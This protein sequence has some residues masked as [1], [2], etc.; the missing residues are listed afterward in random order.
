MFLAENINLNGVFLD[1]QTQNTDTYFAA[2]ALSAGYAMFDNKIGDK[3]RVVWGAR[4]E[5]FQ[6]F[7]NATDLAL[8]D[9]IV[10]TEKVDVLPSFNATYSFTRQHQLRISGSKTVARPEFREIAPFQ[11]FDYEQIWGIAGN[12]SLKRSSILNGDVRYEWYPKS[13]EL[14]S[15]GAFFKSFKDPIELRMDPGSNGDRWLFNYANADA[16]S[17]WGAEV[18]FRKN[19]DFFGKSFEDFTL[20]G[21]LTLLSSQVKLTTLSAGKE[22]TVS[23]D[24][25]LYGQSPYLINA[26]L[27]YTKGGINASLLYNR[28]GPRL[29]LVGDPPPFGAG[30]YD[31][32]EA[33]RNVLD[34]TIAAKVMQKKGEVKLTVS[35][36]INNRYQY[37]DNPSAK[38]GF[39]YADGDRINFAFRPGTTITLGF[40]YEFKL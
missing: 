8:Q 31:I 19:L 14:V 4:V 3:L 5:V 26:G 27:Q 23:Q 21:N 39:S 28:V 17:L 12:P 18:E 16:A 40:N 34:F 35:D 20:V 24:R 10:N 33:P 30:F 15:V 13:G 22:E 29:Y 32:Y 37:Y 9:I 11:F 1:D 38:A 7:L 25:P 36:I 6:Q 2:S